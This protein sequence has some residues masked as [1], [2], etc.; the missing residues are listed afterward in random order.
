M[1]GAR[2]SS[3]IDEF[4]TRGRQQDLD[5]YY[6]SQIFFGVPRQNIRN[7][8]DRLKLFKQTLRDV[9]NMSQDIEVFDRKNDDIKEMC[10]VA[11]S[12]R[13]NYQCF[14]MT[15]KKKVIIVFS[16]K[17]KTDILKAFPKVKLFKNIEEYITFRFFVKKYFH[18]LLNVVFN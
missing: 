2:N 14:D 4:F 13:L 1:L 12:E 8:S 17:A 5:V 6:I 7:N 15:K 11:W 9:Q 16:T 3:Q 10:R 18:I